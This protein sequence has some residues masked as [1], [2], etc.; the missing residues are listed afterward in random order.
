MRESITRATDRERQRDG[1]ADSQRETERQ[2][3]REMQSSSSLITLASTLWTAL[4]VQLAHSLYS[5]QRLH[6][7][8]MHCCLVCV[9][10]VVW[11]WSV[12]LG[13]AC[14]C[15]CHIELSPGATCPACAL[16]AL[17][18]RLLYLAVMALLGSAESTACSRRVHR[19]ADRLTQHRI[20]HRTAA[21]AE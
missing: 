17:P 7:L 12:I 2:R 21:A 16:Q 3:D 1:E 5:S 4:K 9:L 19:N 11:L 8:F 13:L 10:S 18:G 14:Q 6:A 20:G 15:G